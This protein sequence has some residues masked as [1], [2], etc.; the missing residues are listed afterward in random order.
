[1]EHR[2]RTDAVARPGGSI[3][4]Q[5]FSRSPRARHRVAESRLR[6]KAGPAATARGRR[7]A[8][9]AGSLRADDPAPTTGP[10]RGD[11]GP[12]RSR[13]RVDSR[14]LGVAAGEPRVRL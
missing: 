7:P 9:A 5:I 3:R 11:R 4:E 6:S 1:M 14:P 12:A 10:E 13:V 2:A 8:A